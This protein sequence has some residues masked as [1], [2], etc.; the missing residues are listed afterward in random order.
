VTFETTRLEID[1]VD[2]VVKIIGKGPAVL[3]L[4]GAA[5]IEG[6]EW[7]RGLA[8]QA[9]LGQRRPRGRASILCRALGISQCRKT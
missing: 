2:T 5:T 1:G 3:A 4:H 6:F 9:E 7:A 8:S